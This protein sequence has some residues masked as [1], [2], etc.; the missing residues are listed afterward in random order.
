MGN[1]IPKIIHYA[2]FG[3]KPKPP[4]VLRCIESW[5]K[6]LPDFEIK[7]LNENNF[8]INSNTYT[9]DAYLNKKWAFVSDYARLKALYEEGGVYLDTDMYIVKNFDFLNHDLIL[10]KEGNEHLNAAM[11]ACTRKNPYIKD[12]LSV[13]ENLEERETI[14]RVMTK[15]FNENKNKYTSENMDIKMFEAVY[16]YPF[17][18]EN[19][20]KFNY[21]NAPSESY[22]V[23]LWNYSWGNPIN[24]LIKK[25]GI[26]KYAKYIFE[27]LKIKNLTKKILKM[28]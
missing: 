23:H 7:E 5:K 27:K 19:I 11:L 9:K 6:N 4:I 21:N 3:S 1:K 12:L 8:D 22:G 14:P 10:G 24:K 18:H 13:Y 26:H 17:T 28:E 25:I 15:V 20:N 16:F 2:W